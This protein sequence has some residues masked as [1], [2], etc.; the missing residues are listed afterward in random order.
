[1]SSDISLKQSIMG[2]Y[3]KEV[4]NKLCYRL[5]DDS[6][7]LGR[8]VATNTQYYNMTEKM[9]YIFDIIHIIYGIRDAIN[10]SLIDWNEMITYE[11]P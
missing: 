4:D 5:F 11:K 2:S 1:M 6:L 9:D 8:V 3:M 10:N 7:P